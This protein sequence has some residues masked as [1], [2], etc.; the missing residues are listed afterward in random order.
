MSYIKV[1]GFFF[2]NVLNLNQVLDF[3]V[4]Q[5]DYKWYVMFMSKRAK[6]IHLL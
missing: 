4:R 5:D 3:S 2:K 1:V 6:R